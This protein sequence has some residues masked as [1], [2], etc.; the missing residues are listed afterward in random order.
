MNWKHTTSAFILGILAVIFSYD[1]IAD[2]FGQHATISEAL[3]NWVNASLPN[4]IIFVSIIVVF[5]THIIF[6]YYKKD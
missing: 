3:T 6:G 5:S 1:T 4:L 2:L